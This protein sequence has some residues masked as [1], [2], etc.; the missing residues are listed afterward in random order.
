MNMPLVLLN[1]RRRGTG[2]NP[3]SLFGLNEQ[4]VWYDPSDVANLAWRRNLLTYSESFDNA[5]WVK[6]EITTP[7]NVA[8]APDG[9]MT[10]DKFVP[11][12]NAVQHRLQQSITQADGA[13]T[14]T[15]YVKSDGSNVNNVTLFNGGSACFAFF[16][17]STLATSGE[18]NVVSTSITDV[19]SGWYRLQATWPA[20]QP[21]NRLWVY[22]SSGT[23]GISPVAGNGTDGIFLWGAQ[24]EAGSVATDYQRITDVNTEVIERFPTAT[25]YQDTI[26]TIPV[27]TPGQAVALML[28]KS[29]GLTLG[30]ELVV[31][32]TFDTNLTSWTTTAPATATWNAGQVNLARNSGS[33]VQN[34]FQT[35]SLTTG[36]SYRV[37]ITV[38]ALS[39]S[40]SL[41]STGGGA[42][43]GASITAPGVYTF[44][45]Q[46]LSGDTGVYVGC[47]GS[48][49]A[50]ATID[51][52][53]VRELPGN[54]AT[55]GTIASRPT[56][57]VV[58]QGGRRNLLTYSEQ[59]NDA[60]WSTENL[61]TV[62]PNSTAAPDG[63]TTADT[64]TPNTTSGIHQF[65][66][67]I[68]VTPST[69]Y[70]SSVYVKPNGYTKI[71]LVE[72]NTTGAYATFD[73]TGS[74]SVLAS[75][76]GGSGAIVSVG[77][78]W[79][80]ISLSMTTTAAQTT[81]RL[82]V[83]FL[84]DSYSTGAP[85]TSWAGNGTS[86]M[87]LWG[88]Q[89]EQ[90][91]TATPYQRVSTIY[92]VTEAGVPSCSYLFFDGGSDS[93]AT[94]NIDFTATD[95]MTVF[96]GVRKN[97]DASIGII[98]EMS[99]T[100]D[101]AAGVF[102]TG[103]SVGGANYASTIR[104]G[105]SSGTNGRTATTF[106]A[107]ISNVLAFQ[108]DFAQAAAVDE[109]LVRVNGVVPTLSTPGGPAGAGNFGN[110]PLYIGARAG[111]SLFFNGNLFGLVV[112][113]AAS[114]TAQITATE[115]WLAPKTG[116]TL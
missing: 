34:L 22:A 20:T 18:A 27:T 36:R 26:G 50:T 1:R 45:Y 63:T 12:T 57:G 61:L 64:A 43:I 71:A 72:N 6:T 74:G 66:R 14:G 56:Y 100:F 91:A 16:N 83:R 31:N 35:L 11:S 2:F 98:A 101:S 77:N 37:S 65:L 115:A 116:V 60:V 81:Y 47:G 38:T 108:Y 114:T 95:K 52:I 30:A 85:S 94:G 93:M 33:S 73:C 46:W 9:T 54:H 78:G 17:I 58:P 29:R 40:V 3:A 55:Q 90:S 39:H 67:S 19:G 92:D 84:P 13:C 76:I 10:A 59:F 53:S 62:S 8:V 104:G 23:L 96:A 68:T 69:A 25:L 7:A 5:A 15:I 82:D 111:T 97:S 79:F 51:N 44:T 103:A 87:F 109:N 75:G 113:G 110:Y 70:T 102:S 28:D 88:A 32:G 42:P 80:R 89:L 86:G 99:A 107:P 4:G 48:T 24:L 49:T 21:T 41:F 105:T 106:T 112:R